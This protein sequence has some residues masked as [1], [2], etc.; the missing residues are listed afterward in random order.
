MG[1]GLGFLVVGTRQNGLPGPWVARA[2][3]LT[4]T[5]SAGRRRQGNFETRTRLLRFSSLIDAINRKVGIGI[6]W[7]IPLMTIASALNAASRNLF[8]ASSNAFFEIR[9]YWIGEASVSN[10]IAGQQLTYR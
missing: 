3:P 4:H 2:Y 8:S 10:F 9:C 6:G 7:L 1:D 5:A